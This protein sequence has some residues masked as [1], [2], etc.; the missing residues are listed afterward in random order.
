MKKDVL[1][2][3]L[4]RVASE[5]LAEERYRKDDDGCLLVELDGTT[6]VVRVDDGP[7]GQPRV[8]MT[9]E[10]RNGVEAT[11]GLLASLNRANAVSPHVRFVLGDGVIR[12]VVEVVAESLEPT[13]LKNGLALLETAAAHVE[14]MLQLP[15]AVA[16]E[17]ADDAEDDDE[18]Q[19][20]TGVS[21]DL[22]RAVGPAA[23]AVVPGGDV[24]PPDP[25][26]ADG[27]RTIRLGLGG[28]L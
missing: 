21:R 14:E 25:S 17:G 1:V 9:A 6:A 19:H 12:G 13:D 16:T 5:V 27:A 8:V 24:L 23:H 4:D 11:E 22:V 3:W 7:F 20:P 26:P 10:F 18:Q 28:Y 15:S 2:A